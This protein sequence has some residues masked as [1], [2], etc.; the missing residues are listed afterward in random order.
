MSL[1]LAHWQPHSRKAIA[2][3]ARLHLARGRLRRR[4]GQE[5]DLAPARQHSSRG[6]ALPVRHG[7]LTLFALTVFVAGVLSQEFAADVWQSAMQ[8]AIES[9]EDVG[10]A[11]DAV[12]AQPNSQGTHAGT[13]F[14]DI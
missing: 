8:S 6:L 1:S 5:Q 11:A 14:F 10:A 12:A 4:L 9:Q 13:S 7:H 3:G 2:R